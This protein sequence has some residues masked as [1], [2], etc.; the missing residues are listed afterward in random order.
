M[1]LA[2][3]D[4]R[5]AESVE[6]LV[7]LLGELGDDA[8][9]L[10]GGQSLVPSLNLRLSRPEVL[11][12]INRLP[13]AGG[14]EEM[15]DGSLRLLP[16]TRHRQLERDARIAADLPLVAK[17][18]PHVAHVAIRN[19]GTVGGSLALGDPAAEL[20]AVLTAYDARIV[21]RS[22]D[23]TRRL[24]IRDFYT[25]LYANER[26]PDEYLA[27]IE[28]PPVPAGERIAFGELARRCGDYA[29]AGVALRMRLDGDLV[30][31]A[32]LV[33]FG[34][35][36]RPVVVPDAAEICRGRSPDAALSRDLAE[37]SCQG[38]EPLSDPTTSAEARL[39]LTRVLVTRAVA[40]VVR[41][42]GDASRPAGD[43]LQ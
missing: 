7:D 6:D 22:R 32:T 1:K 14:I 31:D 16:L 38:W 20:P 29:L 4:Y 12:D 9:I 2:P 13:D 21:L 23:E 39:H 36:D 28:V 34:V 11:V 30:A 41:G 35:A 19:R 37:A 27:A 18:M 40:A 25:G 17:A 5:V 43:L 3:V 26:R 10:A 15:D 33:L 42:D 24:P 8:A